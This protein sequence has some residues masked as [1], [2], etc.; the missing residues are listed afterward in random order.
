MQFETIGLTSDHA[1]T[2]LKAHLL[3]NL[4]DLPIKVLDLGPAKPSPSVDYPD[5]A[6]LA[7]QQIMSKQ[8]DGAIA[9]CGTGIGMSIACNKHPNI[10]AA[11]PWDEYTTKMSRQHNNCNILCLGAR[12]MSESLAWKCV[13]AWV[14]TSFEGKRHQNRLDKIKSIENRYMKI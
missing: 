7:A 6:S 1:G 3:K 10:I 4:Q 8:L 2:Q 14:E 11:A 5:Y 9:I 13:L 12:T